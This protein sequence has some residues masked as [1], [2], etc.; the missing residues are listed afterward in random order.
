[1]VDHR[2]ANNGHCQFNVSIA[3]D[4]KIAKEGFAQLAPKIAKPCCWITA[5]R[6]GRHYDLNLE[7]NRES[8]SPTYLSRLRP[9]VR[10]T[11]YTIRVQT[12]RALATRRLELL[13]PV[14]RLGP[15]GAKAPLRRNRFLS[16]PR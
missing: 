3:S 14:L 15:H 1:M 4:I 10:L 7:R 2:P 5:W 11:L 12:K 16:G 13:G 6:N 8:Y 9:G